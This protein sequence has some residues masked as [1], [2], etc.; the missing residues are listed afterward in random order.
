MLISLG[1]ERPLAF[2]RLFALG[3]PLAWFYKTSATVAHI[4]AL[5][6]APR[7]PISPG[8]NLTKLDCSIFAAPSL[9]SDSIL[10]IST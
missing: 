2:L 9:Y 3:V 1:C 6:S 8:Q 5:S 10:M 7:S 4:G